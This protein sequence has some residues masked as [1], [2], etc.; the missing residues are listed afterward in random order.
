MS[1]EN[2]VRFW[3]QIRSERIVVVDRKTEKTVSID[4]NNL[5]EYNTEPIIENSDLLFAYNWNKKSKPFQRVNENYMVKT[6][7]NSTL[8]RDECKEYLALLES[9]SWQTF[10]EM[11]FIEINC[12]YH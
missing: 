9:K 2:Y 1:N 11:M 7:P 10:D 3:S 12:F 5:K 6:G 8:S 4:N